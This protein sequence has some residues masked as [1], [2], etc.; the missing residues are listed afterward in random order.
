MSNVVVGGLALAGAAIVL[1]C[2][3]HAEIVRR[4]R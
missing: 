2:T 3:A 4:L 1:A